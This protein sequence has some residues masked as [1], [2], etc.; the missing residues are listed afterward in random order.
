MSRAFGDSLAVGTI[1]DL[2]AADCS[3]AFLVGFSADLDGTRVELR[4]TP[5]GRTCHVVAERWRA[6]T[7][8]FD[9]QLLNRRFATRLLAGAPKRVVFPVVYGA[10]LDLARLAALFGAVVELGPTVSEP[11]GPRA[12]RW[13]ELLRELVAAPPPP[14]DP[15]DAAGYEAYAFS[16]RDH[17]LLYRMQQPMV[18]HF[19][20]CRTVLDLGCGTGLFLD[21][22][23]RAGLAGC[24]VE[25]NALSARYARS[26]G[27]RVIESGAFEF[28]EATTEKFDGVHCSHFVE[29]LP[30]EA[31]D[32]LLALIARVL[33]PGGCAVLVFPDPESIRSQLLG[34]WRDPEHVR[35][36]HPDLIE[37]MCTMKGLA[38]EFHSQRVAGRRVVPFAMSPAL[39]EAASPATVDFEVPVPARPVGWR[40]KLLRRLGLAGHARTAALEARVDR[41]DREIRRARAREIE[42]EAAVRTLWDVNQTWAWDDNAVLRVRKPR[43]D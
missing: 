7:D 15:G 30:T 41:L 29:H 36:Y 14:V 21:A 24:G 27:H 16:Q 18:E 35:F 37:M 23:Q 39:T 31:V 26:M 13:T 3:D 17:G 2:A 40:G 38:C 1:E 12:V 32:R 20:G 43:P 25:R 9:Q 5:G 33:A 22:L 11:V 42:L 34:F 4:E 28:L 10:T 6:V 19:A 8:D